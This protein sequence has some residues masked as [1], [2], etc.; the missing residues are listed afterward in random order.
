MAVMWKESRIDSSVQNSTTNATGLIQ[1]MPATAGAL[2]TTVADLKSMDPVQQ[3]D[4]V[5]KYYDM[6]GMTGKMKSYSDL[7]MA[8]FFPAAVGWSDDSIL[9]TSQLKAETV[10]GANPGIDLNKDKKITV[11]EFKKYCLKGLP[12]NVI[13]YVK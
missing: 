5:Y 13:Q 12:T 1:F 6:L 2:G 11:A 9:K 10:A 7:Y 4:Y 8:T 3:L